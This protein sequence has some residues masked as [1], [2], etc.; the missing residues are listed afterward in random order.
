MLPLGS[1]KLLTGRI[2]FQSVK[3][4]NGANP[5]NKVHALNPESAPVKSVTR[6]QSDRSRPTPN[7]SPSS[8][9]N[10]RRKR[11]FKTTVSRWRQECGHKADF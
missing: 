1:E 7:V 5:I 4:L 6:R 11:F 2:I 9:M 10:L 8:G 3:L